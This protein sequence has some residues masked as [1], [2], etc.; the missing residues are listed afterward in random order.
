MSENR[1]RAQREKCP[2]G[3][4]VSCPTHLFIGEDEARGLYQDTWETHI[5]LG[6]V[7]TV[8][9]DGKRS[10]EWDFD[11]GKQI[12][13]SPE[14]HLT[15]IREDEEDT[16]LVRAIIA[17]DNQTSVEVPPVPVPPVGE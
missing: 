12:F 4:K 13:K 9:K 14:D 1:P 5:E 17:Q 11:D 3:S 15:E 16:E 6:I 7:K 2:K 10:V 8:H